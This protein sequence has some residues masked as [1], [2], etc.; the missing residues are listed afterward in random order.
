[1]KH[2]KE[3]DSGVDCD[4]K[5]CHYW[6]ERPTHTKRCWLRINGI[7]GTESCKEYYPKQEAKL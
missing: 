6:D 1:M 2:K 7:N 4:V 3:R 5:M